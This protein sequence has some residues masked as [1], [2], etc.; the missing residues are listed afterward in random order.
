MRIVS[1]KTMRVYDVQLP[2]PGENSLICPECTPDRKKKTAKSFSFNA[3][4]K[5]GKCFHCETS[6]VEYRDQPQRKAFVVPE[7]KNRTQLTDRA[8]S[9][10]RGRAISDETLNSLTVSSATEFMPQTGKEESVIC[11]PYFRE[12]KL[13][14]IKYRDARKN[15]KLVKDAELVLYNL[16]SI[17]GA[18]DCVIVEGEIDCLSFIQAGIKNVVSVPNGANAGHLEYIDNCFS[19][20]EPI[21]RFF[22]AVDN[23]PAG[24]KLREELVRRLGA[25]KCSIVSFDECKDANEYLVK[26]GA[27]DLYDTLKRAKEVPISGVI[28]QEQIY[29][30]IY[31]LFLNGLVPGKS[32]Q[33]EPLDKCITWE[34]GR[35]AVVTG[36]PGHGK[37]EIVDYII[38]R[39]N[40]MHGWKTAYYSPENYPLEIHYS[41]IASKISGKSFDSKYLTQEDFNQVFQHVN[42]NFFFIYPEEDVT[43]ENI[44]LKAKQTIRRYGIKVLVIDPYNKL[45]HSRDRGESETE[46]ISRFLDKISMF[47]KQN[48]IIVFLVAHPRKMEKQKDDKT[49]F[50]QPTLYDINGSANFYNKADYGLVVYRDFTAGI[51]KVIVSKVKFKHL[52]EGGEVEFV[53]NPT[54]GR[55]H[56]PHEFPDY[57]NYLRR[58]WN[59]EPEYMP[60]YEQEDIPF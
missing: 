17:T 11:F 51:V 18:L 55:I 16:D 24:F 29:D 25:E 2:K 38:T 49:K 5:A 33:I 42:Q 41:K 53:Y 54:N 19:Q 30:N 60:K 56:L 47:A 21:E 45:E 48:D 12:G 6:F 52:G 8:L 32:L 39:L 57:D 22:I 7:W 58:D 31:S 20:L 15:F 43:I 35:I 28:L 34:T 37:S 59:R 1:L 23:D 10:F 36:I 4:K 46:Y 27:M 14:N 13:V 50:E 9:W 3:E 40:L 26:H 44:L